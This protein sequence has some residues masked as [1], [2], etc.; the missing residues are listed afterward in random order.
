VQDAQYQRIMR[1]LPR[2]EM[3][4]VEIPVGT[5]TNA[6]DTT[7]AT[8]DNR[9]Y[10]FVFAWSSGHVGSTSLSSA[11][12]YGSPAYVAFTF[13]FN[14]VSTSFPS[15]EAEYEFVKNHFMGYKLA[16]RGVKTTLVDLGH[17]INYFY[18]EL[19]RYL[20]EETKYRFLLVRIIRDRYEAAVSLTQR[21][22][23][24]MH[25]N[26]DDYRKK[27]GHGMCGCYMWGYCPSVN[28]QDIMLPIPGGRATW[29]NFTWYQQGLW[30]V[31]EVEA[32]WPVLLE[33]FPHLESLDVVWGKRWP[34]S[35]ER[36]AD[37][38]GALLRVG[39]LSGVTP[40]HLKVHGGVKTEGTEVQLETA[41]QDAQYQR[42]MR[43]LPRGEM[44]PVEMPP[45]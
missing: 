29:D 5:K 17:H 20:T 45:I 18:R 36:A 13:E 6:T 44:E 42:I 12:T 25:Y 1:G 2:G 43:G 23:R 28:P 8:E 11:K 14:G 19:V 31:D 3:E 30:I 22:Q 16:A 4:P 40:A 34:G 24:G 33:E 27:A 38:I 10:D 37:R 21:E 26:V 15:R 9:P 41:L 32:R 7:N 39:N 35:M